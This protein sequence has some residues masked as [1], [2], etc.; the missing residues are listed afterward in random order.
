MLM[1]AEAGGVDSMTFPVTNSPACLSVLLCRYRQC[2]HARFATPSGPPVYN[3]CAEGCTMANKHT[4]FVCFISTST[5]PHTGRE[6]RR[7]SRLSLSYRSS[8][9]LLLLLFKVDRRRCNSL[10]LQTPCLPTSLALSSPTILR[11][12]DLRSFTPA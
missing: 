3:G 10:L 7:S 4:G 12:R 8:L 5:C 9:L 2:T 1:Y 11:R 6:A